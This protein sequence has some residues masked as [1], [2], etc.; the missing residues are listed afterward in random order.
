MGIH[1]LTFYKKEK[2]IEH[3][4]SH[5]PSFYYAGQTSTVIPYNKLNELWSHQDHF[6]LCDL[7]QLPKKLELTE[8]NQLI[9][10]GGVSWSEASD[11]L[12]TKNRE[13]MTSPTE[14]LA[15]I[16]A[17]VATSCTG[18]RS[19]RFGPLS[20]QINSIRYINFNGEEIELKKKQTLFKSYHK[21]QQLYQPYLSFKNAPFPKLH[22]DIDLMI[23]TEGQLGVITQVQLETTPIE[24]S[25]TMMILIPPWQKDNKAHIEILNKIQPFR[26]SINICELIDANSFEYL[27]PEER[28]NHKQDAIFIDILTKD[29][30]SIYEKFITQLKTVDE[31]HIFELG[32][33][34]FTHIRKS[35]PRAVAE[36]NIHNKVV[37][38]GTD[39]QVH[40]TQFQLL[41]DEYKLFT[42]RGIPCILFGHFGDAHLHFNFLGQE[43]DQMLINEILND[44]YEKI[45]AWKV[46]PFA[47][48]G[49][50]V[51][52]QKFMRNFWNDTHYETFKQLKKR[53]DPHNQFFPQG[54]LNLKEIQ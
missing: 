11:F 54:F 14:D 33:S 42:E 20:N 44:F 1:N 28:P 49:I 26:K 46:S 47:E 32:H 10:E 4:R 36:Y 18:E 7:S 31:N 25:T 41:L 15:H 48:H 45:S 8:N 2:L 38:K 5:Q 52:K 23:G 43:S 37:K 27:K 19:F 16:T 13:L 30:E 51:L 17:G 29:F 34:K 24:K 6:Y 35:I 3:I 21:Y 53:F 39:I 40:I 50:G 9:V 12:Q 22:N